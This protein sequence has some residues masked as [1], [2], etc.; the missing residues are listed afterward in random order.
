MAEVIF[1]CFSQQTFYS[2]AH[3]YADY[4][5]INRLIFCAFYHF[6][7]DIDLLALNYQT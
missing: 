3:S 2:S 4:F 5:A 6:P 7:A 1:Y